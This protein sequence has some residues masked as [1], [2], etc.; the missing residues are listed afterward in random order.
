MKACQG[1]HRLKY[2][3][4]GRSAKT[5]ARVIWVGQTITVKK[6]KQSKSK[7]GWATQ[8]KNNKLQNSDNKTES[9][10]H[11]NIHDKLK[12]IT[13]IT[14]ITSSW[15]CHSQAMLN[16]IKKYLTSTYCVTNMHLA[17][18]LCWLKPGWILL[19]A[20]PGGRWY[21][22]WCQPSSTDLWNEL[23]TEYQRR[24]LLAPIIPV[25]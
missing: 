20:S 8:E 14:S 2:I 3:R 25:F 18:P 19:L 24:N 9:N 10:K 21:T 22:V 17:A 4:K 15:Y 23:N 6:S 16:S 5:Q 12:T 11:R 1:T 7:A 13:K